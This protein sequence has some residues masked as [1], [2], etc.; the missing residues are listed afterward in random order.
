M[1]FKDYLNEVRL[2]KAEYIDLKNVG[3]NGIKVGNAFKPK[4]PTK[5]TVQ[6]FDEV[7]LAGYGWGEVEKTLPN[8]VKVNLNPG[9]GNKPNIVTVKYDQIIV[10]KYKF[11]YAWYNLKREID[12]KTR[13]AKEK[14]I[15]K[16]VDKHNP[17]D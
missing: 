11:S 17:W 9:M 8:N 15:D 12:V 2:T 7:M 13:R 4:T 10:W 5:K 3:K 1:K 6:Q 14:K 16:Y